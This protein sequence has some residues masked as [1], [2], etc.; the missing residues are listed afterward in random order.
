MSEYSI[1]TFLE[2][3]A[4]SDLERVII[5]LISQGLTNEQIL[6][7]ILKRVKVKKR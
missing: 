1:A 3:L 4:D 7:E 2:R 5:G 6:E